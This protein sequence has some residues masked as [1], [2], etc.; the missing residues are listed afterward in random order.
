ML[1]KIL[2]VDK[3][4]EL[5]QILNYQMLN[6]WSQVYY[7]FLLIYYYCGTRWFQVHYHVLLV[8]LLVSSVGYGTGLVVTFIALWLL[9][10]AQPALLY[11]VPFTLIPTF[12][13]AAIRGEV[14]AMWRG[15]SDKV[16][17]LGHVW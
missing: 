13:V 8:I 7:I 1:G 10:G 11:L 12:I 17:V 9:N 16:R 2:V 14:K 5:P 4:A 6:Y 15:D 3:S